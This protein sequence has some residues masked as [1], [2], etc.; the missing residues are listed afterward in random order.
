MADPLSSYHGPAATTGPASASSRSANG[1]QILPRVGPV[2]L[3][4]EEAVRFPAFARSKPVVAL[5]GVQN[6]L[7]ENH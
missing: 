2:G 1:G 3:L 4:A 6:H 5:M 7:H